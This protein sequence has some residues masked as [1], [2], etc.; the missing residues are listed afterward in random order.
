MPLI[1][2]RI[3]IDK[4]LHQRV[5]SSLGLIAFDMESINNCISFNFLIFV[6]EE[7]YIIFRMRIESESSD[8]VLIVEPQLDIVFCKPKPAKKVHN[9]PKEDVLNY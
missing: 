5:S 8:F 3:G 4:Y 2:I 9:E 6:N 7:L 1:I